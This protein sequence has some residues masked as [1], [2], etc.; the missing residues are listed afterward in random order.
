MRFLFYADGAARV[1]ERD[2]PITFGIADM[3]R[4]DR[5]TRLPSRGRGEHIRQPMAEEN[6]VAKH[7]CNRIVADERRPKNEAL[8]QAGGL[9]LFGVADA[10]A[11]LFAVAEQSLKLTAIHRCCDYKDVTDTREHQNR[12]RIVDHRLVVDRQELLAHSAGDRIEPR[13][14][15]SSENNPF[16]GVNSIR[17]V[18]SLRDTSSESRHGE[19]RTPKTRCALDES[20]REYCGR[21]AGVGGSTVAMARSS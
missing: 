4:E 10:D 21:R 2:D 3:I 18:S 12:Q 13:P 17:L 7:H 9:G 14:V 8:C 11:P 19:S 6:I 5:R 16:H 20:R 1:V 15:A